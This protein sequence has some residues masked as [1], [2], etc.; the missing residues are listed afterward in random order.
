MTNGEKYKGAKERSRAFE[1]FCDAVDG[2]CDECPLRFTERGLTYECLLK[3]LDLEAEDEKPLPCPFCGGE[4]SI[5][6]NNIVYCRMSGCSYLGGGDG[7]SREKAISAHNRVARAVMKAK[8]SEA[9]DEVH[10]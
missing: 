5:D 7:D 2:D 3:W 9:N 10:Y 4:C 6:N 8:E 1:A